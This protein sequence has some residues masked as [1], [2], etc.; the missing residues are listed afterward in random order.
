MSFEKP[1]FELTKSFLAKYLRVPVG[2]FENQVL[3]FIKP[4]PKLE[5]IAASSVFYKTFS[6]YLP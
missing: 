1:T 6:G 2:I 3:S 5:K 4:N